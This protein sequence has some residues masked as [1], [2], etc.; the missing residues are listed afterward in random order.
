[1]TVG[2]NLVLES[3]NFKAEYIETLWNTYNKNEDEAYEQQD[4]DVFYAILL[5]ISIYYKYTQTN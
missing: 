4:Q 3:G 5:I 2:Q 1:M